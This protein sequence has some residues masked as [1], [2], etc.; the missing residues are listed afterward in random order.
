[1][2]FI[3]ASASFVHGF[4]CGQIWEMIKSKREVEDYVF[5]SENID[6]VHMI[7]DHYKVGRVINHY[8]ETWSYLTVIYQ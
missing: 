8:D 5:H 7:C 6:Q 1:M 4:E 3:D 2:P